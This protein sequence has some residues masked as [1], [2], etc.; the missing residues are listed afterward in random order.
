MRLCLFWFPPGSHP[1]GWRMPDAVA[2]AES[3]FEVYLEVTRIAE[4]AKM[5]AIF[6][7]DAAAVQP[8]DLIAKGDPKELLADC[9]DHRVR[10]FLT[11]GQ[12]DGKN[13]DAEKSD[14]KKSEGSH[15]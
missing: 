2:T 14:A 7:A 15:G 6:F 5:D 10:T 1:G 13:T 11:R 12:E 9:T 3:S 4:A 8:V